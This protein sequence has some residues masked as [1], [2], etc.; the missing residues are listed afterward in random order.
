MMQFSCFVCLNILRICQG[1]DVGRPGTKGKKRQVRQAGEL[2]RPCGVSF[3]ALRF[4][5]SARIWGTVTPPYLQA[6][7]ELRF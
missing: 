3:L 4:L 2:R 1:L 5:G 7:A 6:R